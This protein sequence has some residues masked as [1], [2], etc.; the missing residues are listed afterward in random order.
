MDLIIRNG[1]IVTAHDEFAGDVGIA[2]GKIVSIGHV[3]DE[4]ARVLDAAG[5]LVLPGVIDMHTHIDH[6]GGSAKTDD[7]FFSGTRAAAFGGVTTV[8]D[9]AIQRPGE[10]AEAALRRR[11][12]EADGKVCI[13]YSLH[14]HVT[15]AD[16]RRCGAFRISSSTEPL[17]SKCSR[18]T[19]KPGSRL[20]TMTA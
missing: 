3:R 1:W 11:R 4:R 2:D 6:W 18:P 17:R 9:F 19:R 12:S 5:K 14:A 8:I 16:E 15:G 13:D 20:K 10:T 7:D